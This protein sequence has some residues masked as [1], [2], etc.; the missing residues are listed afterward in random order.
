M[1]RTTDLAGA[2]HD[3]PADRRTAHEALFERIVHRIHAYFYR[4]IWDAAEAEDAL[5]ET[6]LVLERSL[7]Q[8][9][10]DPSR[11]FN[12]WL[13]IKAHSVYVDWCRTRARRPRPA[14]LEFLPSTPD[15]TP[16]SD[17]A[18]DARTVLRRLQAD[19]DDVDYQIFLLRHEGDLSLDAIAAIVGRDRK[20]V[21]KRL[22][23]AHRVVG[24]LLA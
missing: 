14:D 3:A 6:L 21:S 16:A 23:V 1:I 22:E 8:K 4:Q 15:P 12:A 7:R 17:A 5:Q 2:A 11:S 9:T 13:W 18:L 10:Y 19:L 24:R 20:T